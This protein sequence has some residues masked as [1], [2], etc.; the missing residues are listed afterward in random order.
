VL[1]GSFTRTSG[2]SGT[3][4]VADLAGSLLLAG[5]EFYREFTD[6]PVTTA[7]AVALPGMRGAGM[8][9]DLQYV[10]TKNISKLV[11]VKP[12]TGR[13]FKTGAK[14]ASC[15]ESKT[16]PNFELK[17]QRHTA[18]DRFLRCQLKHDTCAGQKSWALDVPLYKKTILA[19][20]S[21]VRS[22]A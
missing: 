22:A 14:P 15:W 20:H 7:A 17:S 21:I 10:Q 8:V 18:A 3:A 9:R 16:K 13:E 19:N 2:Q 12:V 6:D 1:A 4:G 11:V 5:N